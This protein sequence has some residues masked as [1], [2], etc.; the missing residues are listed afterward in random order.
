[1]NK[2]ILKERE[3][4]LYFEEV[5]NIVY[6]AELKSKFDGQASTPDDLTRHIYLST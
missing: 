2:K 1:M 3:R 4:T 5:S 6:K